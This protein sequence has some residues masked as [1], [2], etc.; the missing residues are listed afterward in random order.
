MPDGGNQVANALTERRL[1]TRDKRLQQQFG[2]MDDPH[3]AQEAMAQDLTPANL[4]EL[5]RAI[6]Q[7]TDPRQKAVLMEELARLKEL[8]GNL[9]GPVNKPPMLPGTIPQSG[10]QR[11]PYSGGPQ[12]PDLFGGAY[13]PP[14]LFMD[15]NSRQPI[16]PQPPGLIDKLRGAGQ[17][18]FDNM[19]FPLMNHFEQDAR[20]RGR[21]GPPTAPEAQWDATMKQ[22]HEGT[23]PR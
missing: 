20:G 8:A 3:F 21:V 13:S 22:Y 7:A 1:S 10:T 18:A 6:D 16:P 12:R 14:Q 11:A 2:R 19:W 4:Q 5:G 15:Q 23:L 9:M 17:S